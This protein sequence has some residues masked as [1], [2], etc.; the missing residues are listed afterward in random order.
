M[1][2]KFQI[3]T[4][5]FGLSSLVKTYKKFKIKDKGVKFCSFSGIMFTIKE[6][7]LNQIC[8]ILLG[9]PWT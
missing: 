6:S 1:K 4:G 2:M 7:K 9:W 5:V 8:H 3:C